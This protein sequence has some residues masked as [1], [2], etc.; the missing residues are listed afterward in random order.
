MSEYQYYEFQAI[1][2]PLTPDEQE[3]VASL[4]SRVEP[5]P[6]QAVFVYTFGGGLRRSQRELLAEY[7]DAA[8]YLSNWGSRQ[9]MFRFPQG[10]LDLDQVQSYCVE[11]MEW[12]VDISFSAVDGY[13]ILNIRFDEEGGGY[14]VEGEDWLPSLVSLREDI[15]RGDY[16]ALYLAW[17]KTVERS[18]Y[19]E[20]EMEAVHEPPVPS[21]LRNLTPALERLVEFFEVDE[22]L[23]Q[24]AAQASAEQADI[25]DDDLAQAITCLSREECEAFLLR[26]AQ[27]EPLLSV[28]FNRRLQALTGKVV[29][30]SGPRRTVG[31]LLAAAGR[32]REQVAKRLAE[33]AEA[34]RIR[35]LE[36]LASRQEQIWQRVEALIQQKTGSAYDK[37]VQLLS[38]L[39]DLGVY[40]GREMAFQTRLDGIY[41]RY[42]K[43]SGLLRRLGQANLGQSPAGGL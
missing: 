17:L 43:Y 29:C 33:E 5:H 20:D 6:R 41:E 7:Y 1:D 8:L 27:G 10:L 19:L 37:A 35:E 31:Q 18:V 28:K 22:Y 24:V 9:L 38:R 39:K 42:P 3:A 36:E 30:E 23:V 26:L 40:Q 4:S 14:W 32:E 21:G 34:K 2:R 15:L 11:D 13:V 16:R 25:L 12:F